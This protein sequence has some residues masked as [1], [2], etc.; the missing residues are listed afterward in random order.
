MMSTALTYDELIARCL[1]LQ[2]ALERAELA[3]EWYSNSIEVLNPLR[4]HLN[5]LVEEA[6]THNHFSPSRI[7]AAKEAN[8]KVNEFF[9]PKS[10]Q[11]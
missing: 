1:R 4:W 11:T 8:E 10:K 7:S 5:Q 9:S 3:N 2:L 6:E